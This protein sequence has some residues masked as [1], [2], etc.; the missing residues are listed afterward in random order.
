[1]KLV[2]QF[3]RVVDAVSTRIGSLAYYLVLLCVLI[4]AT[5][6][7]VRKTFQYSSNGLLEIQWY[8]FAAVFLLGSGY[9]LLKDEHVRVDVISGRLSSRGRAWIDLFGSV[10]FL[11]PMTVL[12]A[13][14]SWGDFLNAWRLGEVSP[15]TGGLIVWP[16]RLLIPVGFS[17]LALQ[18]LAEVGRRLAFLGGAIPALHAE[19]LSDEQS[20]ADG[21]AQK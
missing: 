11:L 19:S 18:G 5:N 14:L 10:F 16:A 4:S 17:L 21:D 20:R 7:V 13:W 6:A 15:N 2:L 8:L 12:V 1:M 9:T 3:I